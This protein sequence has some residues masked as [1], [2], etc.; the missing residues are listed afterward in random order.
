MANIIEDRRM[1]DHAS[2]LPTIFSYLTSASLVFG[3]IFDF[4][5]HN[6]VFFGVVF[7]GIT[8]YI[9]FKEKKA[10]IETYAKVGTRSTDIVDN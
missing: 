1:P 7:G 5:N 10:R 3:G 6:A 8:C 4:I 9:N 2:T